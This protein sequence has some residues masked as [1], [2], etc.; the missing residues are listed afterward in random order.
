MPPTYIVF[1]A[2]VVD[3]NARPIAR[4]DV[5]HVIA[6]AVPLSLMRTINFCPSTGEP[7]IVKLV[8]AAAWAVMLYW[9]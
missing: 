3:G 7:V 5:G 9:S 4:N 8:I 2:V 6:R 1:D